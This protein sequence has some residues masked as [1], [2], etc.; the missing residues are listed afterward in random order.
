MSIVRAVLLA[1]ACLPLFAANAG[2]VSFPQADRDRD[3]VVTLA[4]AKRAMPGLAGVH[5]KKC[6]PN[7]DGVVDRGE[8]PLLWNFY[9]MIYVDR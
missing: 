8:Y 4:E 5:F 6:D 7:G 2:A 1:A 3:G 9:W